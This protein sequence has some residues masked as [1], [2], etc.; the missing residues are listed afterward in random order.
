[1][2]P[3]GMEK[4]LL[5]CWMAYQ[6]ESPGFVLGNKT[7]WKWKKS[8]AF[9]RWW[10]SHPVEKINKTDLPQIKGDNKTSLFQTASFTLFLKKNNSIPNSSLGT[11]C[12]P[13]R[14]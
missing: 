9:T 11:F 12:S 3:G 1:M 5:V 4:F 10:L 6:I 14:Q 13:A 2:S 8:N 7:P